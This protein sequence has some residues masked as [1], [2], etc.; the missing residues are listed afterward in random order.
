MVHKHKTPIDSG[1][2]V[3]G[4]Y[5]NCFKVGYNAF[6]FVIDFCQ[7]FK[8]NEETKLYTRIITSPTYAKDLLELL[9]EA[10]TSYE[11]SIGVIHAKD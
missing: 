6:E 5:A 1:K 11:Q 10:I 9:H 4:Q 3:H 2:D 7:Y 8:E